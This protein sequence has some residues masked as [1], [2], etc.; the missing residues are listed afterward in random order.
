MTCSVI[1]LSNYIKVWPPITCTYSNIVQIYHKYSVFIKCDDNFISFIVNVVISHH[2]MLQILLKY[3]CCLVYL[4][5]IDLHINST[6]I[7]RSLHL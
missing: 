3:K 4:T 6:D 1:I 7:I 5:L 2:Y